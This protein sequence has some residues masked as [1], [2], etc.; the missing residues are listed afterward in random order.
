MTP[1]EWQA[2]VGQGLAVLL[3]QWWSIATITVFGEGTDYCRI[4][5]S[6]L[7]PDGLQ[8]VMTEEELRALTP[9]AFTRTFYPCR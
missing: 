1:Q 5:V 9:Y 3:R 6:S 2:R 7:R 4:D 8:I